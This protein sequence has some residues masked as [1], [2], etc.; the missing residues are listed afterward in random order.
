MQPAGQRVQSLKTGRFQGRMG[1]AVRI[2]AGERNVHS[3]F[4]KREKQ[5]DREGTLPARFYPF[6]REVS[7][8]KRVIF[9]KTEPARILRDSSGQVLIRELE[10]SSV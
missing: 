8:V 3:G 5:R 10:L 9:L 2:V 4:G 7:L 6:P 1:S